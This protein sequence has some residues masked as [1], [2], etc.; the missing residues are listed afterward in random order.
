MVGV[1]IA[2]TMLEQARRKAEGRANLSFEVADASALPQGA[3]S[4]DLVTAANMIP[5]FDELARVV[6]PGGTLVVSFSLGPQTPIYVPPE[7][8]RKELGARGF[9]EFAEIDAGRGS[10]FVARKR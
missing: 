9:T 10:A 8:L 2:P 7:R 1:D 4:F 3:A 5:F 6:R